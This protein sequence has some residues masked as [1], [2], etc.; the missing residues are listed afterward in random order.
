MN[1][2]YAKTFATDLK[3]RLAGKKHPKTQLHLLELIEYTTINSGRALHN[4][5]NN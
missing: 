4:E 3:Q 2:K 1:N 5:Y